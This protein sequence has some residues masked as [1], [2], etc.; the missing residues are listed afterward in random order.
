MPWD[1]TFFTRSL[2]NTAARHCLDD[3]MF[4]SVK[5]I[6]NIDNIERVLLREKQS[7]EINSKE[8]KSRVNFEGNH[9]PNYDPPPCQTPATAEH[10]SY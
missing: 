8:L 1:G 2:D 4:N 10:T 5:G 7:L 9:F 6:L 3:K